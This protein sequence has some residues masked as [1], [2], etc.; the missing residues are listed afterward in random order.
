[1]PLALSLSKGGVSRNFH[2]ASSAWLGGLFGLCVTLIVFA[3]ASWLAAGIEATSAGKVLLQEP[4]G[5]VW[6][7][8]A[9]LVLA[10]GDGSKDSVRL[11]SRINWQISPRWLGAALRLDAPC[12]TQTASVDVTALLDGDALAWTLKSPRTALPAALLTGL[13]SPWNTLQL[14]GD[15]QLST[16]QLTG[17]LTSGGISN[18]TGQALLQANNVTTAL[19]TVRPLGSYRFTTAGATVRLETQTD[20]GQDAALL[21]GGAGRVEQ[22]QFT[23]LGEATA[24]KGREDALS[25]LLHMIGQSQ[26]SADGRMRSILKI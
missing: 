16:E 17:R 6:V 14:A 26:P 4:R 21:L 12:C 13:G 20:T 25:N 8:S 11:P 3:P 23:F 24:A 5:T 18:I 19:S 7:G 2:L 1:M 10:G 15:L 22:G 9:Q